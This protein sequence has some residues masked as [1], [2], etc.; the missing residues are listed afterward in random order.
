MRM[1]FRS[2]FGCSVVE[3]C[4]GGDGDGIVENEPNALNG[5]PDRPAA[6]NLMM[7]MNEWMTERILPFVE[8]VEIALFYLGRSRSSE[9]FGGF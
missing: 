1:V 5:W 2:D 7:R 8:C 3:C 9:D 6:H 4:P